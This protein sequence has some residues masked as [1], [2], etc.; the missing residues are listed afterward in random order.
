[1]RKLIFLITVIILFSCSEKKEYIHNILNLKDDIS[2]ND[3]S[4]F[5]ISNNNILERYGKPINIS[6]SEYEC[7]SY[8]N[9]T[10]NVLFEIIHYSGFELIGSKKSF[11]SLHNID[12][13]TLPKNKI[14][15]INNI[16]LNEEMTR[17]NIIKG[18]E[19]KYDFQKYDNSLVFPTN[20]DFQLVLEFRNNK[21]YKCYLNESC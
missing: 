11:Y 2:L 17:E 3:N 15:K 19:K 12:F 1:M 5:E 6:T 4:I 16:I 14:F 9:E 18:F 7:G 8:S 13:K 20:S 10:Q 21:L